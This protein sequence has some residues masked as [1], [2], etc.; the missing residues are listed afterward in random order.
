MVSEFDFDTQVSQIL[1]KWRK[2]AG[3]TQE[4]IA[5]KLDVTRRTI[6]SL[7][8]GEKHLKFFTIFQWAEATRRSIEK[9]TAEL[10][11]I[12]HTGDLDRMAK[13]LIDRVA[14][15][16]PDEIKGVYFIF[17]GDHKSDLH[18]FIQLCVA[19]LQCPMRDKQS[20]TLQIINNYRNAALRDELVQPDDARPDIDLLSHAQEQGRK[21][22][23]DDR[24]TYDIKLHK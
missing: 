12:S 6:V 14:L 18:A 20:I 24:D 9:L 7:E 13:A 11:G 21:A 4:D 17:F 15:F 5:R 22:F 8:N 16:T 23:I 10:W 1:A 3:L 19:Y 2:E